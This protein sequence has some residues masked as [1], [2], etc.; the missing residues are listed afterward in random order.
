MSTPSMNPGC[1]RWTL[2]GDAVSSVGSP[3]VT[4]RVRWWRTLMR[5]GV[6]VRGEAGQDY[7]TDLCTSGLI[8]L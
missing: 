7:V 6:N 5:E 2:G 4:G 3:A 8:L 1:D